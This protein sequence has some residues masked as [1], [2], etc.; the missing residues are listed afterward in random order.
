MTIEE[1]FLKYVAF[2]TMSNEESES[3]PSSEKQLK[4]AE[5]IVNELHE[6]GV[7]NAEVDAT[8]TFT[9]LSRQTPTV[10]TL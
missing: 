7:E 4:L 6:I 9:H 10:L 2:P 8:D 1:R 3:C 5:Y